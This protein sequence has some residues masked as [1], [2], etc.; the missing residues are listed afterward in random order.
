MTLYDL[1]DDVMKYY[2]NITIII[3]NNCLHLISLY[4]EGDESENGAREKADDSNKDGEDVFDDILGDIATHPHGTEWSTHTPIVQIELFG[5]YDGVGCIF[6]CMLARIII[7]EFH[8]SGHE[9]LYDCGLAI[10]HWNSC[11]L[12]LYLPLYD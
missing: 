1:N 5:T 2:R 9:F 10:V 11:Q 12:S 7:V 6:T 3:G 4:C 8:L